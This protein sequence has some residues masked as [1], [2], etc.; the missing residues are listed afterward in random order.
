MDVQKLIERIP[1]A[2]VLIGIIIVGILILVI[3]ISVNGLRGTSISTSV[4]QLTGLL[5]II[6]GSFLAAYMKA[7]C[8]GDRK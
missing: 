5:L 7:I 4:I 1:R 3:D 2:R 6:G 8:K